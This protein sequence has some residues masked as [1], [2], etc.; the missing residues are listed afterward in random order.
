MHDLVGEIQKEA[1]AGGVDLDNA[2]DDDG[3]EEEEEEE[4]GSEPDDE[5]IEADVMAEDLEELYELPSRNSAL[6][7]ALEEA[8]NADF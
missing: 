5:Q 8:V 4:S 7:T 1:I 6:E 3:S 2:G